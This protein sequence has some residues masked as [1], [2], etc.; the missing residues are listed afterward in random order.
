METIS[1]HTGTIPDAPQVV[2]CWLCHRPLT[3]TARWIEVLDG[4]LCR[5]ACIR[6]AQQVLE[7]R[8]V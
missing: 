8:D 7:L 3:P 2:R 5:R 6:Q 4:W 1:D